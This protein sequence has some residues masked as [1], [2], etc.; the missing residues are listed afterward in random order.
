[1]ITPIPLNMENEG[2]GMLNGKRRPLYNTTTTTTKGLVPPSKGT[3]KSQLQP[4]S[5][6]MRDKVVSEMKRLSFHLSFASFPLFCLLPP[7]SPLLPYPLPSLPPSPCLSSP[8]SPLSSSPPSPLP[9]LS[10]P[11]QASPNSTVEYD[12]EFELQV[13]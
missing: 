9:S 6:G 1:M 10:P 11:L 4:P 12:P 13:S 3:T 7:F 2:T 5:A 8:S